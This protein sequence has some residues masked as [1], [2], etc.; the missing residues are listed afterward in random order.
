MQNTIAQVKSAI[1]G[2][3]WIAPGSTAIIPATY[4]LPADMTFEANQSYLVAGMSFRT[5]RNLTVPVTVKAGEKLFFYTN[6]KR[7]G[8]QDPDFSVSVLL[9]TVEAEAVITTTKAGAEAWK[10]SNQAPAQA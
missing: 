4:T 10:N 9:P 6:T 5:D 2:K 1:I 3:A 8:K 7:P